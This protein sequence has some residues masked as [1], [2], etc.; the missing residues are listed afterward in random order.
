MIYVSFLSLRRFLFVTLSFVTLS[1]GTFFF[2][3][4]AFCEDIVPH[5]KLGQLQ[6]TSPD[7]SGVNRPFKLDNLRLVFTIGE[8][9]KNLELGKTFDVAAGKGCLTISYGEIYTASQCDISIVEKTM[10]KIQLATLVVRWNN[11]N[12]DVDFGPHPKLA[13]QTQDANR[14]ISAVLDPLISDQTIV[15]MIIPAMSVSAILED[16]YTG[17]LY[18]ANSS[19]APNHISEFV[20]NPPELRATVELDFIDGLPVFNADPN[21]LVAKY[22]NI[23]P[24]FGNSQVPASFNQNRYGRFFLDYGYNFYKFF[25]SAGNKQKITAFPLLP[26]YQTYYTIAINEHTIHPVL[27]ANQTTRI[28]VATLNVHH[29][30]SNSK[31]SFKVFSDKTKKGTWTENLQPDLRLNAD[32]RVLKSVY[33]PTETSLFFPIGYRFRLD[34]YLRDALDRTTLQEQIEV[35]LTHENP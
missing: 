23:S 19:L 3:S 11:A 5:E 7:V 20:I 6:I 16:P 32:P 4:S 17:P 18:K 10:T 21:Y 28:P 12:F 13:L 27:T 35:D 30:Q 22:S 15:P 34:F 8:N 31:G 24:G 9:S 2:V 14:K 26:A 33:Y 29:Y 25:Y 1:F